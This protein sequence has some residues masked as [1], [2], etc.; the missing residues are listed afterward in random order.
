MGMS[1]AD[2]F[3][4]ARDADSPQRR[5][6]RAEILRVPPARGTRIRCIRGC[7]WLTMDSCPEDVVLEAGESHSITARVPALVYALES[8]SVVEVISCVSRAST[9]GSPVPA[10]S[11]T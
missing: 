5:L 1:P 11:A 8:D 4:A 2:W 7:V 3:R 6:G 9:R 10:F